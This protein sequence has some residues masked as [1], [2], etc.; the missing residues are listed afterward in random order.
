VDRIALLV[1]AVLPAV[2]LLAYATEKARS[3][4]LS[5]ALVAALLLGAVVAIGAGGVELALGFVV[6]HWIAAPLP[7]SAITALLVAALPEEGGKF[8]VLLA[9]AAKHV[10]VRRR[11][12]LLVMAMA[13]ALGFAAMENVLHLASA[14]DWRSVAA[15]RAASS[16]PGHGVYGLIMG[17]L[18]ILARSQPHA[19]RWRLLAALALPVLMHAAYDWPLLLLQA[20]APPMMPVLDWLIVTALSAILAVRLCNRALAAADAAEA[21]AGAWPARRA[22]KSAIL[23]G[24]GAIFLYG[25]AGLLAAVLPHAAAHEIWVAGAVGLIPLILGIDLLRTG[26]RRVAPA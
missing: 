26:L 11:Q 10:H 12:D 9:I 15:I 18:L 19:T 16:V 2:A 22:A 3:I 14:D 21:N 7:H 1:A 17:A 13:I 4:G 8:V 23:L 25:S 6:D 5:E 20:G 24:A